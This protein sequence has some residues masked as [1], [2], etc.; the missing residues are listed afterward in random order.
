MFDNLTADSLLDKMATIDEEK[1]LREYATQADKEAYDEAE[2]HRVLHGDV[3]YGMTQKLWLGKKAKMVIT[4]AGGGEHAWGY[5]LKFN[6]E[7]E[8]ELFVQSLTDGVQRL[9]GMQLALFQDG[10]GS[11]CIEYVKVVKS[12]Y[13]FADDE[14]RITNPDYDEDYDE[15]EGEEEEKE[16]N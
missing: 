9:R 2:E 1:A 14:V 13:V 15:D 8:Y 4:M 7:D 6:S 16:G 3:V 5:E 11:S 10:H 12:D